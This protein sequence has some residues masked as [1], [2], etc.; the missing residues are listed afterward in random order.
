VGYRVEH[1][2]DMRNAPQK[3]WETGHKVI[4]M[5][6]GVS[7]FNILAHCMAGSS[8]KDGISE[9]GGILSTSAGQMLEKNLGSEAYCTQ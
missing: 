6:L 7:T 4:P 5:N 1:E 9:V 2:E 3:S 8:R